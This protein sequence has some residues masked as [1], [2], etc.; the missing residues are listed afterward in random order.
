MKHYLIHF[1]YADEMSK[2][3]WR[4]QSCSVYAKDEVHARRV[5]YELYGLAECQYEI[6]SVTEID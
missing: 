3:E 5:C 4:E 2:W 6:L 1:R